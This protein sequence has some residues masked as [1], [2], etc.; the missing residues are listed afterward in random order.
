MAIRQKL[1]PGLIALAIGSFGPFVAHAAQILPGFNTTTYG[2]NDDGTYPCT[3]SNAGTPSNC[4]PQ[5]VP[6]GFDIN[7][8]GLTFSQL[9]VNNNGNVTFNAPL[10]TYTPFGLTGNIG[11]PIIAPFFGD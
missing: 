9:Y 10:S 6:I 1:L 8:Y 11:T 5:A 7:F 3:G 2:A 4:T